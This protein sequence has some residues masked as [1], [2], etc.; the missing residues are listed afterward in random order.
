MPSPCIYPDPCEFKFQD[1]NVDPCDTCK[2][3]LDY[4]ISE[5]MIS[6]DT[7]IRTVLDSQKHKR[8]SVKGKICIVVGCTRPVIA[9]NLCWPCYNRKR[10][11]EAKGLVFDFKLNKH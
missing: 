7:K 6:P 8:I 3:T 5:G 11:C 1:K 4:A 2:L 9:K 10:K